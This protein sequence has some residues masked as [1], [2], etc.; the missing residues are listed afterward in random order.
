MPSSLK[1]LLVMNGSSSIIFNYIGIFINLYLWEKGQNIFDI[2]WFNLIL[3]ISWGICFL[4]GAQMITK[5][6]IS[7]IMRTSAIFAGLTFLILSL[8]HFEPKLLY[9][10]LIAI[11][12]GASNGFYSAASNLGLS[13]FGKGKEFADYF[14]ASNLIGQV[15]AFVNPILFALVI[16]G[17][18]FIGSFVL[19]LIFVSNMVVISYFL[20]ILT[21]A[22]E[23]KPLLQDMQITKVFFTPS[24]K[25]MLPSLLAAGFFLQFQNVFSLIFTFS[26]TEDKLLIALLQVTYTTCT[27]ISLYLYKKYKDNGKLSDSFWLTLGMIAASLGFMIALFPAVPILIISNILT[28][29]GLFFFFAIWNSRQFVT[30]SQYEPIHQARILV[31]REL[32]LVFSR[33]VM[34][35]LTLTI[36]DFNGFAFKAIMIFCLICALSIPYFSKMSIESEKA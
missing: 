19:M 31:W 3:F 32:V 17:F 14:V 36:R 30:I 22:N 27:L 33:V 5:Y 15:I 21:L 11:P 24:L 20:P 2:A 10:A 18:G 13:L 7:I 6:S 34:L 25:W 16:K 35:A 1:R 12:A 23:K 4:I 29:V 9:I 8:I 26:V 28:T